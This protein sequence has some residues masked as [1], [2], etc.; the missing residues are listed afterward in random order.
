[1]KYFFKKNLTLVFFCF[2]LAILFYIFKD[3]FFNIKNN[4]IDWYDRPYVIWTMYQNIN[5]I[6]ALDFTHFFDT[7]AFYP[8]SQGSLFFS[9]L[10]LPQSLIAL[11]FSFFTSNPILVFNLVF[12][13][14]FILNYVSLWFFWKLFFK[15]KYLLF[16]GTL[17]VTFS[18]F[19][20]NQ[21]GHFQMLTFWPFFS[22]IYFL[23][24]G[25]SIRDKKLIILASFF[26]VIQFLASVYLALILLTVVCV[27]LFLTFLFEQKNRR[28]IILNFSIFMLIFLVFSFVFIY[29]YFSTSKTYK[30]KREYGDYITYSAHASDYLFSNGINSVIHQKISLIK[31]WNKNNHHYVGELASSPGFLLSIFGVLGFIY[32]LRKKNNIG[33][34]FLSLIVVGFVFSLGP[35]LNWN[36]VYHPIRLPYLIL[37][38]HIPVFEAMRAEAR[39]SFLVYFGLTYFSLLFLEK[40]RSKQKPLLFFGVLFF[41]L[42]EYYPLPY[43]SSYEEYLPKNYKILNKTCTSNK[44]LIEIPVT[45]LYV[46]PGLIY[47]LNY[48]SK[49]ELASLYHTCTMING[50]S[51]YLFADM[52]VADQKIVNYLDKNDYQGIVNFLKT[53]RVD[54]VKFNFDKLIVS[55]SKIKKLK[56]WLNNQTSLTRISDNIYLINKQ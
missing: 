40:I 5:H 41:F 27:Y 32:F 31:E 56:Y 55:N 21:L 35:R 4:L 44:V 38:K 30:I 9:D 28:T 13:L 47:G 49:L 3:L 11:L 22:A 43:K 29:G 10:L 23:I 20:F 7:N 39:W 52:I 51:G 37:I 54:L 48:I 45:H 6:K 17:L 1:M 18:P 2:F 53:R 14:T 36:G 24:K 42:F 26:V 46:K 19:Y 16:L 12:L 33:W 8:R 34:F 15:E 50:Y 25:S